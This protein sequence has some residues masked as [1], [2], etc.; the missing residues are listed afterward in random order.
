MQV[1]FGHF[2]S[3]KALSLGKPHRQNLVDGF[4]VIS[5]GP[6]VRVAGRWHFPDK[7]L[8][9][10]PRTFAAQTNDGNSPPPAGWLPQ[11]SG[12]WLPR[13]AFIESKNSA[14][15]LVCFIFEIRNSTAS[16]VPIGFRILRSR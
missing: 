8:S 6:E 14:L 12:P 10:M 9:G 1:Q 16:V 13:Q 2:F 4:F 3:G 11:R 7:A 5:Q 15:L